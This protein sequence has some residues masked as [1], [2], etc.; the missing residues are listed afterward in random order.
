MKQT[1]ES[2]ID[3]ARKQKSG[4]A[5]T[6]RETKHGRVLLTLVPFWRPNSAKQGIRKTWELNGKQIS[7]AKLIKLG[8]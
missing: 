5:W 7:A 6:S 4:C 8:L 3:D 1:M 2:M